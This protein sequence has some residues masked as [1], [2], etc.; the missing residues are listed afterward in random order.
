[1]DIL[2]GNPYSQQF[3]S[4]GAHR[5]NL[6]DY[7]IDLNTDQRLD[8]RKYNRPV[9]SQVAAILVEG[10][11]LAKRFDRRITL[12]G[13]DNQRHSIHVTDGSYDPL[14]YPLFYPRG[15]LGWHPKLH[16]RDVPWPVIQQPRGSR[17]DDDEDVGM[18]YAYSV[19]SINSIILI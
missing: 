13:N 19:V 6:D 18:P 4:L 8:Q 14:S 1:V 9:S 10:T 2:R 7:R 15:E 17:D 16:K 12:C 5:D 11:D 3:R